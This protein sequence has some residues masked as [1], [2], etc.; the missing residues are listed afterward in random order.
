LLGLSR[1]RV[2]RDIEFVVNRPGPALGRRKW[3]AKGAEC[4]VDHHSFSG[5]LYGFH[6]D[7][8]HVRMPATGRLIWELM[9]VT[10]F[11]RGGDRETLHSTKWLKLLSG[12]QVDVL[13]WIGAHSNATA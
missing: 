13:R 4:S 11:S 7:I 12:K 1:T 8:L 5:E 10:E 6:A 2:I 9:L 3:A